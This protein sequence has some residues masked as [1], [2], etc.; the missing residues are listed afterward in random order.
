M[1]IFSHFFCNLRFLVLLWGKWCYIQESNHLFIPSPKPHS[2]PPPSPNVLSAV[3]APSGSLLL[4]TA[5]CCEY[6]LQELMALLNGTIYLSICIEPGK[7]TIWSTSCLAFPLSLYC[8]SHFL[9]G[10]SLSKPS[11]SKSLSKALLLGNW[12]KIQVSVNLLPKYIWLS[13]C[14]FCLEK[15]YWTTIHLKLYSNLWKISKLSVWCQ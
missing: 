11:A 13:D 8:F 4:V 15:G 14:Y 1:R 5:R 12:P 7:Q 9:I 3:S 2:P 10:L 6:W